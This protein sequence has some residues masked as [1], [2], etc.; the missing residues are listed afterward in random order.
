MSAPKLAPPDPRWFQIASLSTLLLYGWGWLEFDVTPARVALLVG[1]ALLTQYLCTRIWKL[2]SFEPKSAMISALSLCLLL[3]TNH[4]IV[5]VGAAVVAVASKFVIRWNDK[6]I[7]NP[8]NGALVAVLLSGLGWVSPGQWGNGAFLGFLFACAGSLV[9]YRSERSD[10]TYAFLAFWALI[11]FGRSWSVLEPITIPLHR[12][13]S[14]SLL[15]FAFFMISDPRTTPDSRA[16]RVL[17]AGL[18]AGIAWYIQFKLFR[19]NGL[20]W[21]LGIVAPFVP[22]IDRLLPGGRIQWDLAGFRPSV[23]AAPEP[24]PAK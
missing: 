2:P 12:L 21:S 10:I 8:T 18:V 11:L 13:E 20:L 16:G 14:G 4:E 6:H 19:T 22:V 3:R 15:L 9:V 1:T 23:T 7:F 17:F 24:L 5:A